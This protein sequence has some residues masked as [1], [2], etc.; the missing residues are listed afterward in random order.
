MTRLEYFRNFNI[1]AEIDL[2]GSF[3]Y[4][5]L[6]II[7][8]A[9]DIYQNDQIFL[10]LY[11]AAVGVER[12]QKCVL[13]MYGDYKE[14]DIDQ[15]ANTIK[16]H[17]HQKLQ[18]KI[19]EYTGLKLPRDQNALL[20]LLQE[21][22]AKGRYSNLSATDEYDYKRKFEDYVKTCYGESMIEKHFFREDTY[23][24]EQAKEHIGRTL[25]KLLYSYYELVRDKAHE[26][27]LYTYE[28]RDGSPA[29]KVFLNSFPKRSLQAVNDSERNSFAELIVFMSNSMKTTG[30]FNFIRSIQP[31]DLDPHMVQ[32]YLV[33]IMNRQIP[34]SLVDEVTTIYEDMPPEEVQERKEM[35]SIIGE[36]NVFFEEDEETEDE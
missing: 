13:F 9:Q 3:A 31:L 27:N 32:E 34:Q 2:A 30:Y 33:D 8:T 15:F 28:L 11:N 19:I 5:A 36:H 10:F 16:S 21:Y 22:Y 7:N 35:V 25:G 14:S 23:V 18:A 29:Q 20:L 26:L 17:G 1:G 12:M 24:T 6:S 4:N